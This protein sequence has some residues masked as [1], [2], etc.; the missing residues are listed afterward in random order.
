MNPVS[1]ENFG[2]D[3]WSTLAYV[4]T[5]CV[6][7]EGILGLEQMKC[8]PDEHPGLHGSRGCGWKE[9]YSTVLKDGTQV[10]GHDDWSCIEDMEREGLIIW[11]GTGIHPV[12]SLTD[13][14]WEISGKLR[15]HISQGKKISEFEIEDLK[16]LTKQ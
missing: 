15:K 16:C 10:S 1:I 12:F 7:H 9:S 5:R 3:H 13:I 4:E 6:D 8:N 11:G 2:E 14:G